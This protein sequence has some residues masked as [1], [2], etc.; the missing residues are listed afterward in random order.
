MEEL[1]VVVKQSPAKIEWNFEELKTALSQ[2]LE[3]YQNLVYT[4]ATIKSA[5][6]DLAMLRK[7]KTAI[8]DQQK[9]IKKSIMEPYNAIKAQA[10]E[11]TGLIEKPIEMINQQVKAY[12]DERKKKV[13]H[14][15]FDYMKSNPL[16]KNENFERFAK[17]IY[18]TK[19]ENATARRSAWMEAI[20]QAFASW[21]ADLDVLAS[22][23]AEFQAEVTKVYYHDFDLRNAM[24]RLSDLREQKE[25]IIRV[26]RE[27]IEAEVRARAEEERR[28]AEEA[29]IKRQARELADKETTAKGEAVST[30]APVSPPDPI[31]SPLPEPQKKDAVEMKPA[32]IPEID[33]PTTEAETGSDVVTAAIL[34]SCP[35]GKLDAIMNYLKLIGVH[36]ELTEVH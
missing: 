25:R 27:R 17:K 19:W 15:I 24:A 9:A 30:P 12:E 20:D 14:E 2:Q 23:E 3:E 34:V 31:H 1:Q 6:T 26:E 10:D 18:D 13:R 4:D 36:G 16:A 29:E 11:L 5:K 33:A 22:A 32:V 21:R 8:D 35:R 7:L 28:I